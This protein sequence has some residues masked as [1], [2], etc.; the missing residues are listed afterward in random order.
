MRA[1]TLW[2]GLCFLAAACAPHIE[3]SGADLGKP[4][5]ISQGYL[6]ED[7]VI[8]PLRF[9]GP[10][11]P[12]AVILGLHGFGDYSNAFQAA[13]R[14]LAGHGLRLYAY[15]QRGFGGSPGRGYWHGADRMIRDAFQAVGLVTRR[16][17]DTPVYLLGLSMGGA[18]AMAAAAEQPDLPLE[19]LIL[20]APAVWGR[21]YMPAYQREA[22]QWGARLVPWYPLSGGGFRITPSDNQE[23]LRRLAND[24]RIMRRFR[25]DMLWGLANLMDRAVAAAPQLPAQSL[26]LAG[27]NDEIVPLAPTKSVLARAR[28]AHLASV[29]VG[30]YEDGYHMLLRDRNG[31]A[32]IDDIAAWIARPEAPL[33]SG[34]DI[35]W[36]TRLARR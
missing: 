33:P 6:T 25:I 27:M 12:E 11:R 17:P 18:V 16:H 2:V 26:F 14:R 35:D 23:M 24:P 29:R 8:L 9:W 34:A 28:A 13:G 1:A 15:D 30:L 36:P 21:Q 4:E 10:E 7:G 20:V 19:G 3:P 5:I 31:P 22:L 32:V